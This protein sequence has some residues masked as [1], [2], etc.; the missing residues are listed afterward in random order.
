MTISFFIKQSQNKIQKLRINGIHQFA[1]FYLYPRLSLSKTLTPSLL[2][3]SLKKKKNPDLQVKKKIWKKKP[4]QSSKSNITANSLNKQ[5]RR[6]LPRSNWAMPP[7]RF[8]R[9]KNGRLSYCYTDDIEGSHTS[10]FLLFRKR[11]RWIFK[12]Y[13]AFWRGYSRIKKRL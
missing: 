1:G 4:Q 12:S 5:Y 3:G 10:D 11:G 8:Q 13:W 9:R 2:L 7:F 6:V